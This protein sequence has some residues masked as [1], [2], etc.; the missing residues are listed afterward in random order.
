MKYFI[1]VE[2]LV[3]VKIIKNFLDKNYEVIAFK[4]YVRD[5]FKFVLGIKIDEIGFI[6]NYVVDKD[7]KEFVK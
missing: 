6:F 7:Y 5:L 3:K 2:F 1:I 4:G